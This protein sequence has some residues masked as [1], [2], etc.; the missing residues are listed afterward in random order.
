MYGRGY[1]AS[2]THT[3]GPLPLTIYL[4]GSYGQ[5][6]IVARNVEIDARLATSPFVAS[7][8]TVNRTIPTGGYVSYNLGGLVDH[9]VVTG[10]NIGDVVILTF[11]DQL[12]TEWR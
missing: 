3:L 12:Q 7:I 1:V 11:N 8:D 10:G 2:I 5:D 4:R 6:I 9:V